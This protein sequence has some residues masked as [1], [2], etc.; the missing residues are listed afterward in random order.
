VHASSVGAY[1]HGPADKA[2]RVDESWPTGGLATSVYSRD[3]AAVERMLDEAEAER[4]G[5]RVVRVRRAVVLQ[6]R[7]AAEQARYFLGP[8]VP[9]SV[10]RRSFIPIVPDHERFQLQVVHA[11]DVADVFARA[12][13]DDAARGG[14][15]VADEPVLDPQRLGELLG[16]RPVPVKPA[17]LRAFVDA[18]WRL[19]VQPTDPAGSTWPSASRSWTPRRYAAS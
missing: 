5:L 10:V 19:H 11:E 9:V 16:A 7:A 6:R 1:S 4:P 3:K 14:Y 8:F 18:T 12:A 17:A 13:V 2:Q 15:N